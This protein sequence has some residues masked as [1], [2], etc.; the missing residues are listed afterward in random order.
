MLF[1][2]I[3]AFGVVFGGTHAY[4]SAHDYGDAHAGA[5]LSSQH[6][7]ELG[8]DDE[9]TAGE[10]QGKEVAHSHVTMGPLPSA[11]DGASR[12]CK[13]ASPP[14][15]R[16]ALALPSLGTAPPLEPPSV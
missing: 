7:D 8:A 14:V 16:A 3:L 9:N 12:F 15:I 1:A 10:P 13:S 6:G 4:A 11:Q 2:L 5:H